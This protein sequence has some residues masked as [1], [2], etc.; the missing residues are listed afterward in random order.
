VWHLTL[1]DEKVMALKLSE[2][3][4]L[5]HLEHL[6]DLEIELKGLEDL[7]VDME[8]LEDLKVNLKDLYV[9]VP[10][11]RVRGAPG[12]NLITYSVGEGRS[13]RVFTLRGGLSEFGIELTEMN[14]GLAEYF[15]AEEGLLVL[16]VDEDS[17]LGLL[18]GDVVLSIDGREVKDQMDFGRI[19]RSYEDDE[20]VTF[21]VIRK[22]QELQV[23]GTIG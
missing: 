7:K 2:L 10:N 23:E 6:K 4:D 21:T 20:T 1:P 18:P 5:K 19:L 8:A 16:D 3:E 9:D 22:G 17:A 12:E 14:S 11:L 13:P 15:S